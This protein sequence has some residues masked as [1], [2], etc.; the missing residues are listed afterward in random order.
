MTIP[1]ILSHYS[2]LGYSAGDVLSTGT[3]Q[4]RGR[5]SREDAASLYLKPGDVIEAEIERIG[6][7]RNP[8]DLVAGGARRAR[9]RRGCAGEAEGAHHR[10]HRPGWLVP[11]RALTREG[12]RG[13]RHRPPLEL[14]Q[15]GSHRPLCAATRAR[16]LYGDLSD[17][18]VA[19]SLLRRSAR[20]DLQPRGAKP[21][22]GQLRSPGV[23]RRTDRPRHAPPARGDPRGTASHAASTRRGRAKCSALCQEVPQKETTPFYPRR[24]TARQGLRA[25]AHGELSRGVWD[26]RCNGILFNHESPRRGENFVTRKITRGVAAIKLGKQSE[27]SLGNLEAKR[28][29]GYAKDYVH[30]MWRMLQQ[31]EP[32]DYVIAT[33]ETHTVQEFL[34]SRSA[35][36]ARLA[37]ARVVDSVISPGGSRSADR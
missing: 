32:D 2:A 35:R 37:G 27:L 6:V 19:Q 20:R 30:A 1:E 28:D 4:R 26:V 5:A 17:G 11:R 23:H 16:A 10:H 33:G 25:L 13:P 36:G 22:R 31:D 18:F 24:P 14:D 12:V 21:R 34:E 3:R 15:R 9:R 29:W 7:L 8:V